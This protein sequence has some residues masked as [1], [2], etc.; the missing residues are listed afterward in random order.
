[1]IFVSEVNLRKSAQISKIRAG[2]F[3]FFNSRDF[4]TFIWA[5]WDHT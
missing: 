4:G 3:S 1:M 2:F 5:N